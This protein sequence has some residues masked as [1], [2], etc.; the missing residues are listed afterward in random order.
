MLYSDVWVNAG[1]PADSLLLLQ[2]EEELYF[3][4]KALKAAINE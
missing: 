2:E 1:K 3:G 4:Y